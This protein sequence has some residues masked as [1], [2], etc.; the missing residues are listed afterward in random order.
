MPKKRKTDLLRGTLDM[1]ILKCLQRG[2]QHG[3]DIARWIQV[4]TEDVLK[5]EEGS[6]YPSLHRMERR[7]WIKSQWGLSESNRRAKY[8]QL[9]R[10]G[11]SQLVKEVQ[12]WEHLVQAIGL[13]LS[14]PISEH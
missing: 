13:I 11:R 14:D 9:T 12:S 1:L 8:Y 6:L 3:Y 7:G 4:T 10:K 2:Q 5:V